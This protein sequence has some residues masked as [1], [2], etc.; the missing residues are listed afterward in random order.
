MAVLRSAAV[1]VAGAAA[2]T[3]ASL[4]LLKG[5]SSSSTSS[6]VP[7]HQQQQ[8]QQAS[9]FTPSS[10]K[11]TNRL[12]SIPFG[13]P[14]PLSD[15]IVRDAYVLSY[16][17]ATR[18][19]NWTAEHLSRSTLSLPSAGSTDMS[20]SSDQQQQQ[21]QQQVPSRLHSKFVQDPRI[22]EKY[23]SR[24]ADYVGTGY[25]RGHLVPAANVVSSQKAVDETFILS[26]ISPQIAVGFNRGYWA[27]L[28]RFV[29]GLTKNFDDV[30]VV[31]GPLFLPSKDESDGNYYVKYRV[32]GT[33][34]NTAV[35]THFFKVIVAIKD[36]KHYAQAFV[37]PNEAIDLGQR[38]LT[39]FVVPIDAVE[40]SSGLEFFPGLDTRQLPPIC[41]A[42]KCATRLGGMDFLF[43]SLRGEK[44]QPQSASETIDKLCDRLQHSSL[45]EDRRTAVQGLRGLAKDWQLE[46]GTKCMPALITLLKLD[47]MDSE[48][49]KTIIETLN[50]LCTKDKK[51]KDDVDVGMM[52]T[53]TYIED[54]TNVTLLLDLLAEM[55]FYV[56]YDLLQ[57]LTTLLENSG[58]KLQEC[59]LTSPVGI[60]RLID[61]LDDHR[62]IIRN[63]NCHFLYRLIDGISSIVSNADIQKIVAFE[64]AFERLLA[65]I[66]NEG[67]TDGGIIVDDCLQ[68]MMNLLRYNVSN[69]NL[70]RETSGIKQLGR[71]LIS[72]VTTSNYNEPTV[73]LPLTHERTDWTEQKITNVNSVL[74]LIS[75]LVAHKNSNTAMNQTALGQSNVIVPLFQVAMALHVPN[76][77]RSQALLTVGDTIRGHASNQELFGK[78]VIMVATRP[79]ISG[80]PNQ[81]QP[82][83]VPR[84]SLLSII[85]TALGSR[86]DFTIRAAAAY[87]FEAYV[88]NNPDGQ[89]ALISTLVPPPPDNPNSANSEHISL[90]HKCMFTLLYANREGVHLRV[91]IALWSLIAVWLYDCPRAVKE[92]LNEGSNM[93]FL[94]EQVSHSS[95]VQSLVISRIGVDV[96]QSRLERLREA[97]PLNNT[98]IHILKT[99]IEVDPK[100]GP[101]VYFDHLF[102]DFFKSSNDAISR[103]VTTVQSRDALSPSRTPSNSLASAEASKHKAAADALQKTVAL[104]ESEIVELR[105]QLQQLQ[106]QFEQMQSEYGAHINH[107]NGTVQHLEGQ[108]QAER[109]Q[110]LSI[111][112]EQEDLLVCL[113]EQDME[114]SELKQRLRAHGEVFDDDDH[115]E[116]GD[117]EQEKGHSAQEGR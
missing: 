8:Q 20:S 63:G 88:F 5:S 26:N 48:T 42:V 62:E 49:V 51:T 9:P 15:L 25:D 112:K 43:S 81:R 103:L 91:Q 29:R 68:L 31:T 111:E 24:L 34:P 74:K 110:R 1:F 47:R 50:F 64:N 60:S 79:E 44:T 10:T 96:F 108:L 53:E 69:Q 17:R 4:L 40:R 22:P 83:G 101:E 19:P 87:A 73:D 86:E 7:V 116:G 93:Q 84:S 27:G 97:K 2:G 78:S 92:F 80:L 89:L 35:P 90:L 75:I 117:A 85:Q 71:L 39:E 107:L 115:D 109:E 16:N 82:P 105:K 38:P 100:T 28:E 55:D 45:L 76:R 18:N 21:Q 67:A 59:I 70:F 104:Q 65:I 56:R 14:G 46:V 41:G 52:F 61:L 77:V 66:N 72:K 114:N 12:A 3:A 106:Q 102:V 23:Q 113:A 6:P 94:V 95:N 98:S 37:L 13:H 30:Y 57:F 58:A 99:G 54:A 11:S 36:S 32:I 33:P